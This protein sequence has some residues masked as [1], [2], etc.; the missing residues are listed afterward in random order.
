MTLRLQSDTKFSNPLAN[1]PILPDL[2]FKIYAKFDANLVSKDNN[3]RVIEWQGTGSAEP[4]VLKLNKQ[5]ANFTPPLVVSSGGP[6]G[7]QYLAFDG[8]NQL[9]RTDN[10]ASSIY[11]KAPLT[12][13][14]VMRAKP[15]DNT[16]P[17]TRHFSGAGLLNSPSI[18]IRSNSTTGRIYL[19]GGVDYDSGFDGTNW[20]VVTATFN[21][22][23]SIVQFNNSNP[24]ITN[25]GTDGNM[26]SI[27][28]GASLG[29]VN[30]TIGSIYDL[31]YLVSYTR[32]L[33]KEEVQALNQSLVSR[34]IQ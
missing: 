26:S 33:A 23:N 6:K 9:V 20:F 2:G 10:G 25:L 8:K 31:A 11:T 16:N 14:L 28:L 7:N 4:S 24:I 34:Y 3:N 27:S 19:S 13:C 21:G 29:A 5:I 15:S 32:A 18:V 30:S 1:T 12:V 22:T 17:N